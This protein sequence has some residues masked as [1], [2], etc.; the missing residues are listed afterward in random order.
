MA[1][2]NSPAVESTKKSTGLRNYLLKI[3]TSPHYGYSAILALG[4]CLTTALSASGVEIIAFGDSITS[5]SDSNNGGYP[6]QLQQMLEKAGKPSTVYNA[7][8]WRERTHQGSKR[9]DAVLDSIPADIILILEGTN[10]IRSGYPWQTTRL[11]LQLMIDKAKA[12]GVIPILATLTPSDQGNSGVLIPKI[13][14][15]MIRELA[16]QNSIPL[17]DLYRSVESSWAS[18]TDDGLHPN[19]EG[20]LYLA[21]AWYEALE[22]MISPTGEFTRPGTFRLQLVIAAITACLFLYTTIFRRVKIRFPS[23]PTKTKMQK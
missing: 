10:D 18:L 6:V 11:N 14:N 5:G 19:S 2:S 21:K 9:I 20:C 3:F 1:Y 22:K 4:F 16:R 15:P 8:I 7:G 17:V 13:W 12:K 23:P